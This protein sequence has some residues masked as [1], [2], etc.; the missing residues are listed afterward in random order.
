MAHNGPQDQDQEMERVLRDYFAS[1][2]ADIQAPNDLWLRLESQLGEQR[3]GFRSPA[4][5]DSMFPLTGRWRTPAFA[6]A[7]VAA[8]AVG[9]TVAVL[10]TG[11]D[12]PRPS[13]LETNR[14]LSFQDL[15]YESYPTAAPLLE[16]A[17]ESV[18][19][20]MVD[21]EEPSSIV[22]TGTDFDAAEAAAI[23]AQA[24]AESAQGA[25]GA[26][27][28]TGASG[29]RGTEDTMAAPAEEPDSSAS[30][31]AFWS[32]TTPRSTVSE[33]TP[34][35]VT[36]SATQFQ[37]YGRQS[38]VFAFDDPVSTFSL[39]TDR[40]S[41]HLALNWARNGYEVEPDSVRAEEWI[42]AFDYGYQPPSSQREF[43]IYSDVARHPLDDRLH[44]ARVAFQAPEVRDDTPLNVTL[45]L[46]AS[47]SM[48]QGNRV[49]IAREAAE[50]IRNSLGQRDR[51]AVVHFTN[52]VIHEFTVEHKG[53]DDRRVARSISNLAPHGSTN[54]QAGLDLG[55]KLADEARRDRPGAYNYIIL[56]SDGVANVDATNPFAI[57]ESAYDPDRG[58]PLR[59]ITVGVGIENYND[60][61]L[62]QLAQHGD[63]W[64]RYLSDVEQA[65]ST[66]NR[67]NW[68]ALSTPF[69]DQAR[70]QVSWDPDIVRS[71]RI[72][73][74]ENRVTPD[75]TFTQDRKE[76]AELPSGAATTVFYELELH[77]EWDRLSRRQ[78]L[79]GVEVKWVE[80][81]TGT[82]RTQ[83]SAVAGQLNGSFQRDADPWMQ[84]GAI[85]GLAADRYSGWSDERRGSLDYLALGKG[86]HGPYLQDLLEPLN[87]DLGGLVAYSDFRF[88]LG[89]IA[90]TVRDRAPEPT[91]PSGYSPLASS[92]PPNRVQGPQGNVLRPY[93]ATSDRRAMIVPTL[94]RS[95]TNVP[96]RR[97][98]DDPVLV[99]DECSRGS[100]A[101]SQP[102]VHVIVPRRFS[103]RVVQHRERDAPLFHHPGGVLQVVYA[104]GQHLRVQVLY[105]PVHS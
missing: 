93:S 23:A 43:A 51:I 75:A 55:V 48:S 15:G 40:T 22:V 12:D 44:L 98:L 67:D 42:N 2:Q 35:A 25:A 20:A 3:S 14:L 89:H 7:G 63:G 81:S 9:V 56:M 47:G 34:K 4:V 21:A 61:L 17:P 45:V 41:Y 31:D 94:G 88:L 99:Q 50:T 24:A 30:G 72:V 18:D 16:V 66:F 73:G 49:D 71:W 8:I 87:A 46:D 10:T 80:P 65:Q 5:L 29:S 33:L 60:Y 62:E 54:V 36:P 27:G 91:T 38:F 96:T 100:E 58:N 39:D 102:V 70:A 76:F 6:T 26:V 105:L 92:N 83:V 78:R 103:R 77:P 11:G 95:P 104:D 1:E 57:L 84:F 52:S 86:R 82:S 59:I 28:D 32:E 69:A 53:P 68:L 79:A 85:V 101:V 37:D 64:Y 19:E 74:Y 90:Q 97:H 13:A